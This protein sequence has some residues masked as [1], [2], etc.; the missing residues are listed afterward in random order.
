M[1]LQKSYFFNRSAT[2]LLVMRVSSSRAYSSLRAWRP[3]EGKK[4]VSEHVIRVKEAS[5]L[6]L[7]VPLAHAIKVRAEATFGPIN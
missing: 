5:D 6:L 7:M 1:S 2:T 4:D 3:N